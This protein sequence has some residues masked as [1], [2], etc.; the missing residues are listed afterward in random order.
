M[1]LTRRWILLKS[2]SK[3][4]TYRRTPIPD[5]KSWMTDSLR[6]RTPHLPCLTS[7][8]VQEGGTCKKNFDSRIYGSPPP[9]SPSHTRG[10]DRGWAVSTLKK[11]GPTNVTQTS[12]SGTRFLFFFSNSQFPIPCFGNLFSAGSKRP[13]H[14]LFLPRRGRS[15]DHVVIPN[16]I[17]HP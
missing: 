16:S 13:P 2:P 10:I 15:L 3:S 14:P 11:T 12:N 4:G 7:V 8:D 9:H 6:L 17:A 1:A 5:T